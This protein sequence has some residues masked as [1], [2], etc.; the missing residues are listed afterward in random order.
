MRKIFGANSQVKRTSSD[1]RFSAQF[2]KLNQTNYTDM[3]RRPSPTKKTPQTYSNK[4]PPKS[5]PKPQKQ[6]S[7]PYR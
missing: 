7:N 2:T 6:Q 4:M 3:D 1:N 5:I